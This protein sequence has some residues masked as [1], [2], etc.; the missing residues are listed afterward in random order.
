[1]LDNNEGLSESL[2]KDEATRVTRRGFLTHTALAA[3]G[4][5]STAATAVCPAEDVKKADTLS[6]LPNPQRRAAQ[7][8]PPDQ[9]LHLRLQLVR[10]GQTILPRYPVGAAGLGLCQS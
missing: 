1:M 6:A 9:D 8:R 4:L 3:G 7:Q 5:A 10:V 2:E